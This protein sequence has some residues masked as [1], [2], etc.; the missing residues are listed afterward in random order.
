VIE[1]NKVKAQNVFVALFYLLILSV[2]AFA[3]NEK[4]ILLHSTYFGNLENAK[5]KKFSEVRMIELHVWKPYATYQTKISKIFTPSLKFPLDGVLQ[6][7]IKYNEIWK[8]KK[9]GDPEIE[10]HITTIYW[11]N[12]QVQA[13]SYENRFIGNP[14]TGEKMVSPAYK[15]TQLYDRISVFKT[16]EKYR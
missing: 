3:A 12:D 6:V 14:L 9:E 4:N 10:D 5:K 8:A 1:V 11:L 16:L 15:I 13:I 7:S 2:S